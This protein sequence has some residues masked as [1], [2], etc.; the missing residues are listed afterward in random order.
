[1]LPYM[2]LQN[3]HAIRS[4]MLPYHQTNVY[5]YVYLR[6]YPKLSQIQRYM[7]NWM[8]A[9]LGFNTALT[10]GLGISTITKVKQ[11]LIVMKQYQKSLILST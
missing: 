4:L 1:M 10:P 8:F 7:P 6:N 3:I 9:V 5:W 2:H 11:L